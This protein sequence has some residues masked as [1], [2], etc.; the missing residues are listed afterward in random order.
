MENTAGFYKNNQGEL[1]YAP[2]FVEAPTF[3][4]L[5]EEHQAYAYPVD[6]W[7]WF[8]SGEEAYSFFGLE[9]PATQ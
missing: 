8:T 5:K 2:N 9:M 7:Y 1:L 4:L 3:T 6:G